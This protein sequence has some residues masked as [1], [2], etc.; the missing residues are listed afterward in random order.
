VLGG[1]AGG[2]RKAVGLEEQAARLLVHPVHRL[3]MRE[4][5]CAASRAALLATG[6]RG[7]AAG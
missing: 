7:Q 5:S 6:I 4:P 3:R 1:S 2:S